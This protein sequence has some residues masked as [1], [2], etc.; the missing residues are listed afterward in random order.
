MSFSAIGD[1][2][3]SRSLLLS[4]RA[5]NL[6]HV[7]AGGLFG[8]PANF[9]GVAR[10]PGGKMFQNIVYDVQNNQKIHLV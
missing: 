9:F 10:A 3:K 6:I 4:S 1:W 5:V 2:W 7:L 8:Y